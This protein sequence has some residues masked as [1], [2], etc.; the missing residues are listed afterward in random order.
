[1]NR[2]TV[3]SVVLR[4]VFKKIVCFYSDGNDKDVT[5][6]SDLIVYYLSGDVIL[7]CNVFSINIISILAFVYC[8][9]WGNVCYLK[10]K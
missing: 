5:S 10:L 1:M 2:Q 4:K 3:F 8:Y 6:S 7:T 9:A